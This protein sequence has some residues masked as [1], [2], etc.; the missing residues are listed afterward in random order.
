MAT[1]LGRSVS[2][3]SLASLRASF[4]VRHAFRIAIR[5]GVFRA[6]RVSTRTGPARFVHRFSWLRDIE[7]VSPLA[8]PFARSPSLHPPKF[9]NRPKVAGVNSARAPDRDRASYLRVDTGTGE[10]R[11]EGEKKKNIRAWVRY[12]RRSERP[13]D[14]A[15]IFRRAISAGG[16]ERTCVNCHPARLTPS[17]R[18]PP[19]CSLPLPCPGPPLPV[20]MALA[21]KFN[22]R[23]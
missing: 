21:F 20:S 19:P 7:A 9:A 6:F 8:S 1:S 11:S 22:G 23:K 15:R 12:A 16:E 13:R 5:T 4:S 14:L 10:E 3:A 18:F 2:V 17:T